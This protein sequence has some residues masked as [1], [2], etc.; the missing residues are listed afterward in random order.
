V[1]GVERQ[2]EHVLLG[3]QPA[4]IVWVLGL[5]VDLRGARGDPL[6]RD[7]ADRVAEVEVLLRDCVQLG[8]C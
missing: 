8:E 7:P 2:T 3:E 1:L 6:L 5:R 4:E